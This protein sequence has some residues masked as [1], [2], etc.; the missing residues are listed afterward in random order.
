MWFE[1][2]FF[3]Y[4]T[5]I[6]LTLLIVLLLYY[7]AP[8]FYPALWFIAAIFLPIFFA[9]LAYYILRPIVYFIE[10]AKIPRFLAIMI[11]YAVITLVAVAIFLRVGPSLMEEISIVSNLPTEK[12]ESLKTS[13]TNIMEQLKSHLTFAQA[14]EMDQILFSY[15]Q[16]INTFASHVLINTITTLASIALALALTP[17]VL[18]YFLK[19]EDLFSPF[20]LRYTPLDYQDEA[21]KIVKDIDTTLSNFILAQLTV[22]GV[23]GIF[24][25]CGYFIIGL[26]HALSLALFGMIFYVIPLFGTFIAVIPALIVGLAVSPFLAFEVIIVMLIAHFLETNLVTPRLMAYN[27]KIHP[28]T[29]IFLLLA[30]GTLYGLLGLLLVTPTYAIAKVI[31]WNLY[32]IFRLR[33]AVAKAKAQRDETLPS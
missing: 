12:I 5:A 13:V 30:A 28:L 27:L 33:Y 15:V 10:K 22:A 6:I 23:I 19:D 8:V 24:L 2:D 18:F 31:I 25:L 26:P 21:Q 16:K 11:I 14:P 1:E 7:V 29:V 17:F 9:T 32:K 4:A 20:I 3:K